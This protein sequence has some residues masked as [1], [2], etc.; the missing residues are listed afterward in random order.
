[1]TEF[2]EDAPSGAVTLNETTKPVEDIIVSEPQRTKEVE[3][4]NTPDTQDETIKNSPI[5]KTST[6]SLDASTSSGN[7]IDMDNIKLLDEGSTESSIVEDEFTMA[8]AKI[9][10]L[11]SEIPVDP[12][13]PNGIIYQVQVGAFRNEINP[14]I[15]N[16]LTPLVG[17]KTTLG[18]IRYK[19]GYF[20]GFKS[21][22]MAKVRICE[23]GYKD[24]F[25]VVFYDGERITLDRA[26][27]IIKSADESEKFIY[28]NLVQDEIQ[29]LKAIGI[30]EEGIFDDSNDVSESLVVVNNQTSNKINNSVKIVVSN[31]DNGLNNDLLS[32]N[33]LFYTVQ[34]GVFTTPKISSDLKGVTPL[35]TEKTLNGYLRYTTGIYKDYSSADTRKETVRVQGIKDAYVIAY[36]ENQRITVAKAKEVEGTLAN[37]NSNQNDQVGNLKMNKKVTFKVQVGAY[38]TPIVVE[39]TA[40]FKDLTNYE[41]SNIKT[42]SGL[43]IYMIGNNDTKEAADKLRQEVIAV[44]AAD[45]SI[46]KYL[47]ISMIIDN[48]SISIGHSSTQALQLVQAH[49]SSGVI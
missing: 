24:A 46:T 44:G 10:K 28:D 1:M 5:E 45:C 9:Y 27:E 19:V 16:G 6:P 40:V 48:G 4:I 37:K 33:G 23:I 35:Y 17:E 30:K 12:K 32:I 11:A 7:D 31:S 22:N 18:I 49:N 26:E 3:Q 21:A 13:M 25:V 2:L 42:E 29:Q 38:K 15:F 39:N 41:I 8:S 20:R 43:L 36:N 34:V 14:S 47:L